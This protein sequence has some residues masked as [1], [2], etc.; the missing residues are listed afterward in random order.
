MGRLRRVLAALR[1]LTVLAPGYI[2]PDE[3]FQG[4]E[5]MSRDI[6]ELQAT[7]PWEFAEKPPCR[8]V[9]S[10]AL[11]SGIP[12]LGVRLFGPSPGSHWVGTAVLL[13][14]RMWMVALSFTLDIAI[15]RLCGAFGLH[16]HAQSI[17]LAF[18]S[19]WPALLML[20]RPFSNS[21]EA[22]LLGAALIV[23]VGS[24]DRVG[25]ARRW[26]WFGLITALGV[27]TR[28]TFVVFGAVL[29]IWMA[30]DA[31]GWA[32]LWR[33]FRCETL[34]RDRQMWRTLFRNVCGGATAFLA[35]SAVIVLADS[36]YFETLW[37][38]Y[39]CPNHGTVV[40]SPVALMRRVVLGDA[41][42]GTDGRAVASSVGLA[43][44]V[45]QAGYA[46]HL[47]FTPLNS[48]R[49][50]A[51]P[52]NLA[53]HGLHPRW[54]HVA[55][56]MPLM[57]GP[58][59]VL[60]LLELGMWLSCLVSTKKAFLTPKKS[61]HG[62]NAGV[63]RSLPAGHNLRILSASIV[64][65]YVAALSTAPHQEAR[66]LLPLLL[67][68][69]ILYGARVFHGESA[70]FSSLLGMIWIG[71]NVGVSLFFGGLHQA[72]V[73]RALV[74][75]GAGNC[76]NLLSD[77]G[78]TAA[79]TDGMLS[80][81]SSPS[82]IELGLAS[83]PATVV[84]FHTYMP[85]VALTAQYAAGR[86]RVQETIDRRGVGDGPS[87]SGG[88]TDVAILDLTSNSSIAALDST[89]S[90]L[91]TR[92]NGGIDNDEREGF[93]DEPTGRVFVIS[94]G[95]MDLGAMFNDLYEGDGRTRIRG[96][97]VQ[98]VLEP[99]VQWWPHLSMEDPPWE[100]TGWKS[101]HLIDHLL[102]WSRSER[103]S[104]DGL[105]TLVLWRARVSKLEE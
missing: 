104:A 94:P 6:L 8:S 74:Q 47:T 103:G 97:R 36:L 77:D 41:D 17:L 98:L 16:L 62:G 45:A 39:D 38:T 70:S 57:F 101:W 72:G 11:T 5:P 69:S 46:G 80:F 9:V 86:E 105:L 35:A 7:I 12:L 89:L 26:R 4:P 1:W 75:L 29:S 30:V 99:K 88:S 64:V 21:L 66:F 23:T 27:F 59:A 53:K 78:R 28:F 63:E 82:A 67:P 71:L 68:M 81:D 3:F 2:H 50:N 48:Y 49:Y 100:A 34:A 61:A 40:V 37:L 85:P 84:F 10:A 96:T 79:R 43:S 90:N 73:S 95:S 92:G 14:P 56:N 54:T 93:A 60:G 52:A 24:R 33:S 55:V 44:R 76:L 25:A 20:S 83:I 87:A 51:D 22:V 58:L 32:V 31:L 19:A 13:A 42:E 15:V 102:G 91:L 65:F 18:G